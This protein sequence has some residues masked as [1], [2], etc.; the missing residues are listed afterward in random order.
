MSTE[1]DGNSGSHTASRER[2]GELITSEDAEAAGVALDTVATF[3]AGAAAR[4]AR[5]K[6]AHDEQGAAA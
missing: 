1:S 5:D 4:A 6:H 3:L 2:S